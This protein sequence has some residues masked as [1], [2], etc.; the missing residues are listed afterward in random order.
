MFPA[1]SLQSA[2]EHAENVCRQLGEGWKP[3]TWEMSPYNGTSIGWRVVNGQLVVEWHNAT[4]WMAK[5]RRPENDSFQSWVATGAM[6]AEAV[7]NLTDR[8]RN[9]AA[10]LAAQI[11]NLPKGL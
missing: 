9:Y 11:E 10:A 1:T 3:E 2:T 5:H 7:K 4:L 8:M 6:A